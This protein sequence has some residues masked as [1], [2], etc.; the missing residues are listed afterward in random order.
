VHSP[1]PGQGRVTGNATFNNDQGPIVADPFTHNVYAIYAAGEPGIQKGTSADFNNIFVSRSTDG[2][3]TWTANLVFHAPLFTALNNV[4][5]ALAV[6]PTNGKLYVSWSDAHAVF[7]STSS[8]Q[9]SH[10][11]P[12]VAVNIAPANTALFPW[13]AAYGGTIDV[14]YYGTTAASKDDPTAV[15]NTYMAQTTDDGASFVQSLVSNTPNHVGVICTEGTACSAG[16][17]NMLDLFEVAINPSNGKAAVIYTDDTLTTSTDPNNFACFPDQAP[18]C[19][20][21]QVVLAQQN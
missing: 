5:P 4:F 11:T 8:D 1:I 14:V 21:P 13:V 7:F 9:G 10:W 15:W 6:D 16:T 19:P 12:A 18:P 20:L 3:K 2:G 17:R